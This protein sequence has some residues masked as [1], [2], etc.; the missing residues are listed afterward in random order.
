MHAA[1]NSS[2]LWQAARSPMTRLVP[3]VNYLLLWHKGTTTVQDCTERPA[4][5][6]YNFTPTIHRLILQREMNT[7]M[8]EY[9]D[10]LSAE[11]C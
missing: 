9:D 8:H 1:L 3:C 11:H 7:T 6:L 2:L 5:P 4:L 10:A